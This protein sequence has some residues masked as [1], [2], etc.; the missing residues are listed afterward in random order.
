MT[1]HG[2]WTNI[3]KEMWGA[4]RRNTEERI[5]YIAPHIK[6]NTRKYA[7]GLARLVK[8]PRGSTQAAALK[9]PEDLGA[10]SDESL[11]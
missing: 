6:L 4:G 9:G 7:Q 11:N 3:I 2:A 10:E 1:L 5:S 8:P